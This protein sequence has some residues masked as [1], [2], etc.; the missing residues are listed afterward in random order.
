MP[1]CTPCV[2]KDM[3]AEGKVERDR[4]YSCLLTAFCWASLGSVFRQ[5][6]FRFDEPRVSRWQKA[7]GKKAGLESSLQPPE[8]P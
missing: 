6:K 8:E 1:D 3:A 7:W 2:A 5:L 4:L